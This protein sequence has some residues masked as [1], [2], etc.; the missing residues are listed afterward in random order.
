MHMRMQIRQIQMRMN[1]HQKH[2]HTVRRGKLS[3]RATSPRTMWVQSW[4][5]DADTACCIRV[6]VL[7]MWCGITQTS[8]DIFERE[9][10]CTGVNMWM[11]INFC[12]PPERHMHSCKLSTAFL[13]H[14]LFVSMNSIWCHCTCM[15]GQVE[16]SRCYRSKHMIRCSFAAKQEGP[17]RK[18]MTTKMNKIE[19]HITQGRYDQS[20]KLP[21]IILT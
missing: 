21:S 17:C 6:S 5:R 11:Y 14:N 16:W 4:W 18:K 19:K 1:M 7:C 20:V 15:Q 9:H 13:T 3:S 10:V 8:V 12:P 2:T